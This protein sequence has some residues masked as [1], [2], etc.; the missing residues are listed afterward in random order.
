MAGVELLFLL[1]I[2]TW[3]L[4]RLRG[5]RR[6]T[7]GWKRAG[8][9]LLITVTRMYGVHIPL[10]A[11][12]FSAQPVRGPPSVLFS[13]YWGSF[14]ELKRLEL[15]VNHSPPSNAEV[16]NVWNDS[17]CPPICG[18]RQLYLLYKTVEELHP[19]IQPYIP[20]Q[21]THP[22]ILSPTRSSNH[23]PCCVH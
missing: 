17:F 7:S 8:V 2:F 15:E 6:N 14:L 9:T 3:R 10:G 19:V 23:R 20:R 4:D 11:R 5:L 18:R 13:G 12:D 21:S 1:N 22:S 16:K